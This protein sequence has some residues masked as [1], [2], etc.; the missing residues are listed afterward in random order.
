M[1]IS[2]W[3]LKKSKQKTKQNRTKKKAKTNKTKQK[4]EKRNETKKNI[5]FDKGS[6]ATLVQNGQTERLGLK[7]KPE[8]LALTGAIGAV[9][10]IHDEKVSLRLLTEE[11]P[12]TITTSSIPKFAR[13]RFKENRKE[14]QKFEYI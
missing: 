11:G 13:L 4:N 5:I 6:N 1:I 7:N 14:S 10:K 2:F 12:I 8:N 3:E 9:N